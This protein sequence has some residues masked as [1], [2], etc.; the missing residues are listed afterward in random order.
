MQS[1]GNIKVGDRCPKCGAV[2][3]SLSVKT[4]K[5]REYLY[6]YHADR[7]CYL[8][9]ATAVATG[10]AEGVNRHTVSRGVNREPQQQP[11][12][13]DLLSELRGLNARLD[14]LAETV[15]DLMEDI[16]QRDQPEAEEAGTYLIRTVTRSDSRRGKVHLPV[17]WVGKKVKVTIIE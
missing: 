17:E 16:K 8:G 9:P 6:A 14:A 13:D 7:S 1:Y 2:I 11:R 10:P 3:T 15:I 4:I 5:G 12:L